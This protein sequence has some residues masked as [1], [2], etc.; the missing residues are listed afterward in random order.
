MC[1]QYEA[2]RYLQY[3]IH[4][5][6]DFSRCYRWELLWLACQ[7]KRRLFE[8]YLVRLHTFQAVGHLLHHEPQ[9]IIGQHHAPQFRFLT[10]QRQFISKRTAKA[11]LTEVT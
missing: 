7:V 8:P 2:F 1:G 3:L 5:L 9:Q 10:S 4:Y 11:V 6:Q